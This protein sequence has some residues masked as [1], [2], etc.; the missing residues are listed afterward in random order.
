[1]K[2][3]SGVPLSEYLVAAWVLLTSAAAAEATPPK[4]QE[5]LENLRSY[6]A[7]YGSIEVVWNRDY[8]V[9]TENVT[10]PDSVGL[11]NRQSKRHVVMQGSLYFLREERDDT[12]KSGGTN[13]GIS[14]EAYDGDKTR[15]LSGNLV[16]IHEGR[17]DLSQAFYPHTWIVQPDVRV[18]LS[19]FCAGGK[20]L[21]AH[22]SAG[23]YNVADQV[24]YVEAEET[25]DDEPCIRVKVES[26]VAGVPEK[27]YHVYRFWLAT[28]K[29][30]L[31]VRVESFTHRFSRTIAVGKHR[32]S[33]FREIA[34]GV[35]IPTRLDH[36]TF[37]H[38]SA[39]KGKSLLRT[40]ARHELKGVTLTP[41][42]P[43]TFFQQLDFPDGA[44]IVDI[45]NDKI[46]SQTLYTDPGLLPT[47]RRN[48]WWILSLLGL[49][50]A[51]LIARKVSM[52]RQTAT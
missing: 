22:P 19:V 40:S 37:D 30:L 8:R 42:R 26:W 32:A 4:L 34:A 18:P 44:V 23:G 35:W 3:T 9:H 25:V 47:L 49:L 41:N 28:E 5:L 1:M 52:R 51:A 36:E 12:L 38:D 43:V 6:E 14:A 20:E 39:A 50:I 11:T 16:N 48:K 45:R 46:I 7:L 21:K 17:K 15:I 24:T 2:I 31:P 10:V 27:P 13:R 29:N 33:Q